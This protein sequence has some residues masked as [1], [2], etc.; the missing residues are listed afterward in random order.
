S[1]ASVII[2]TMTY[3]IQ[4]THNMKSVKPI[5]HVGL[6]DYE[7]KLAITLKNCGSGVAIVTH[8]SV[9]RK[10]DGSTLNN[11]YVCLPPKLKAGVN[12]SEYWTPNSDFVVQPSQIID[13]IRIPIDVKVP[14][15]IEERQR[16]RMMISDLVVN[17]EYLDIYDNKM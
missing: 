13:L 3:S 8:Y 17:I 1:L 9:Y 6:W 11:L 12:Y 5:L 2:S 15:Q 7:S 4:R 14:E 16:L 10:A